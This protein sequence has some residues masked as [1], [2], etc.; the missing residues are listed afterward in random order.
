MVFS[1]DGG[2]VASGS[3]DRTIRLWDAFNG[4]PLACLHG[5][6][7]LVTSVAFSPDG[8]RI[9]SASVDK[10]VRTWDSADGTQLACLR[11]DDPGVWSSGWSAGKG[12]YVM[13]R[14]SAVAFTADGQH[15]V[16]LSRSGMPFLTET[17]TSLVWDERNG[18]CLK[19]LQ[20]IG[21]FPAVCAGMDWQAVIRG[22]EVEIM[23]AETGQVVGWFPAALSS[24]T[25]HL[26]G[27]TWAGAAG[28]HLYHFAL[29]G[30]E[31]A[32]F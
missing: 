28:K 26:S 20:G 14:T 11:I 30:S 9:V 29:E 1:Q 21:S 31:A 2:R 12:E 17:H 16:T 23:S 3:K 6:E 18:V 32:Q 8:H 7:E 5:H 22:P 13:H 24:L 15:V 19:T 4:A 25:A 10:T 27:R